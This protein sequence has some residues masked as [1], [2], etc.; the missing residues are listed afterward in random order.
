[1]KWVV[2]SFSLISHKK[3]GEVMTLKPTDMLE[4][5]SAIDEYERKFPGRPAP[6]AEV[7]LAWRLG[8]REAKK[9]LASWGEEKPAS[10]VGA[11]PE[12][13]FAQ[14]ECGRL[15]W[16]WEQITLKWQIWTAPKQDDDYSEPAPDVLPW[17]K[18]VL[19]VG[20]WSVVAVAVASVFFFGAFVG[21][22]K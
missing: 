20:W 17:V 2:R 4:I 6:S 19:L 22:L 10:T 3:D 1:M 18:G 5:Q 9:R 12:P 13:E 11:E 8:K 15:A 14:Q 21:G 7:A 16:V